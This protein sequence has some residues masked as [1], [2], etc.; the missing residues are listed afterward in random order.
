MKMHASLP[1]GLVTW[2]STT[3]PGKK[4]KHVMRFH[5]G[6]SEPVNWIWRGRNQT[7]TS[8][9]GEGKGQRSGG[10]RTGVQWCARKHSTTGPD[11]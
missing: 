3:L 1:A 4:S 2:H 6:G 9:V 5:P 11:L 10:K 7:S 8:T